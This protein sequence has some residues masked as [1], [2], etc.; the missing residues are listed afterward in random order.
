MR[1]K[2]LLMGKSG[3]GKT[4][5]RSVIFSNNP[6]SLTSRLGATN[7]VEQN[8][9]RFL[10]DLI[11]NLWDCGGQESFMDSYISTQQGTIFQ[12]VA[13]L[14]YVFEVDP[15]TG[16]ASATVEKDSERE[17]DV[18]YYRACLTALKKHSPGANIFVLIHKMDLVRKNRVEVFERRVKE[19]EEESGPD[20]KVTAFGT[21]IWDESLY[22][23]W[24]RIVH[25]LIPN[26][27][28][29]AKHLTTFA[30]ACGA[31]EVII[32]D[33]TTFLVIATSS[34][35]TTA[36]ELL[37]ATGGVPDRRLAATN[38]LELAHDLEPTR[39]ERTSE[40]IKA[41]KLSCS[42]TH[43]QFQS[44]SVQNATFTAVLEELTR[45]TYM[46]I[47]VHDAIEPDAIRMNIIASR[48]KFE[49]LQSVSIAS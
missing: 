35:S 32:F 37:S 16:I 45:N 25:T 47:V 44:T 8:H 13:V 11:L 17:H 4:S 1:K 29:L 19:L 36:S 40:I 26:V 9:V 39:Y 46:L 33:R 27:N 2:V 43:R 24:S 31:T 5:M 12:H 3:S 49:Q 10:G 15:S 14:I 41:F 6:A 18:S 22:K 42:R 28:V 20:V 30:E 23:A 21:S 48:P 34:T 38:G 7:D